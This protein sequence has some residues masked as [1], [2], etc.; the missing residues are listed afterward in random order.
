[1]T[2]NFRLITNADRPYMVE[3]MQEMNSFFSSLE[4]LENILLNQKE[5]DQILDLSFGH[6]PVC[7]C[8]VATEGDRILGYLAYYFGCWER[9]K[10]M[11]IAGLF[12]RDFSRNQGLGH[13]FMK[14]AHKLANSRNATRLCWDVWTRNPQALGFYLKQ[15]ADLTSEMIQMTQQVNIYN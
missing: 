8:L 15:G 4:G 12:I 5:L 3:I 13:A 1:M 9:E 2:V 11:Y 14:E 10:A 7:E 6:D